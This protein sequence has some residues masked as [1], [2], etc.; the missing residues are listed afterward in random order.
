MQAVAP[1]FEYVPPAHAVHEVLRMPEVN[2][3]L[4]WYVL[5]GHGK[6]LVGPTPPGTLLYVPAAHGN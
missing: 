3:L 4:G 5:G 2:G 6:Q 1:P